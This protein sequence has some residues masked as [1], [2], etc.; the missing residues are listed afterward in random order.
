MR[1]LSGRRRRIADDGPNEAVADFQHNSPR[2]RVTHGR[3]EVDNQSTTS[4]LV[5]PRPSTATQFN[6]SQSTY[7]I[8]MTSVASKIPIKT[9]CHI[10]IVKHVRCFT[11]YAFS[12]AP[13]G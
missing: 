10:V 4:K 5:L 1:S 8:S 9:L 12:N 2:R 13:C 6:I 3:T 11:N 7:K